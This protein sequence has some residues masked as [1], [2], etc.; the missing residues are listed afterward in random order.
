VPIRLALER[1]GEINMK[2]SKLDPMTVLMLV[3]AFGVVVTMLTQNS[4]AS[5]DKA[6][7]NASV[8]E[9]PA[10]VDVNTSKTRPS[11]RAASPKAAQVSFDAQAVMDNSAERAL[12]T[13]TFF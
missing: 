4:V 10:S 11:S 12:S 6:P 3:V 9:K 13:A 8:Q 5:V 7:L 2:L 1:T